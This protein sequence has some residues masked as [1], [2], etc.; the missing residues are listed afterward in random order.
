MGD[1]AASFV[2]A[3]REVT[4]VWFGAEAQRAASS[5]GRAGGRG[6]S[7]THLH[8]L[9]PAGSPRA[10]AL[11]LPPA[12]ETS[13]PPSLS[14]FSLSLCTHTHSWISFAYYSSRAVIIF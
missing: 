3:G 8:L 9:Q 6:C 13:L 14:T 12:L 10:R 7:L 4:A 5:R 2:A 1:S 11:Q